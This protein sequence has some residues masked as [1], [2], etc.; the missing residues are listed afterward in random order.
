MKVLCR[1][2]TLI[3]LFFHLTSKAQ[4]DIQSDWRVDP[5]LKQVAA[6]A[7]GLHIYSKKDGKGGYVNMAVLSEFNRQLKW[8][9]CY[10]VVFDSL[11]LNETD[12]GQIIGNSVD[13]FVFYRD[14]CFSSIFNLEQAEL[15]FRVNGAAVLEDSSHN[16]HVIF[17]SVPVKSASTTLQKLMAIEK[18]MK[19]LCLKLR[20]FDSRSP[21]S[22]FQ[23]SNDSSIAW[24]RLSGAMVSRVDST[25]YFNSDPVARAARIVLRRWVPNKLFVYDHKGG[26]MDSVALKP[27]KY[28]SL[29]KE[30]EDVFLLYRGWLELQWQ[31][32][33]DKRQQYGAWLHKL[34]SSLYRSVSW[35]SSGRQ[36]M[37]SLI[38][39]QEQQESV[40][41]KISSLIV[42]SEEYTEQI[43]AD[44]YNEETSEISYMPGLG[45]AYNVSYRR[46]EKAYELTDQRGNV[47]AVVSDRKKEADE[48]TDGIIE[49][50]NADVVSA[51]DYFSFGMGQP[52]RSYN[53]DRKY[54]YGYDGKENDN[55]IKG[56]GNQQDYGMRIYDPRLGRFL[57]VDPLTEQYPELT[58]YQFASN[59]PI[60]GIDL[61]GQEFLWVETLRKK[62][63]SGYE[64]SVKTVKTAYD[65]SAPYGQAM[66]RGLEKAAKI[67]APV[68]PAEEDDPQTLGEAYESFKKIPSNLAAMPSQLKQ[69]YTEGSGEQKVEGTTTIFFS[70]IG[71]LKGKAPATSLEGLTLAS[72]GLNWS[73]KSVKTFGHIFLEHGA[74]LKITQLADR[75][76]SLGKGIGQWV[77]NEKAA[78]FIKGIYG[79][80]KDGENIVDIPAGLGRIVQKDQ[81][82]IEATKAIIVK[83]AEGA[84]N[85]LKT[86]YPTAENVVR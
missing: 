40:S 5:V 85:A 32:T 9:T 54:R 37:N 84:T 69:L 43:L 65:A 81:S 68:R 28:T 27:G 47:V 36:I 74:Q 61:D 30:K 60:D 34:D 76:R 12:Y 66:G 86:A 58:P 53:I 50:Y 46:G 1:F 20:M 16:N 11:Q 73:W 79:T 22:R 52:G 2:F 6:K 33:L 8:F 71:M 62:I 10:G 82:I 29:L 56:E 39:L 80:L 7:P 55:D 41:D 19:G 72:A 51:N 57:S 42:P 77:N 44:V 38:S 78:E 24:R 70:L 83:N 67:L 21:R 4:T 49:Y 59:R 35:A 13:P 63:S 75:A 23:N 15:R 64:T 3:F 45:F 17:N 25:E 31:Q 26:I 18:M 48:N 14:Y